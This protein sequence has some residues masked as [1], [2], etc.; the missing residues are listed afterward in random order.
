MSVLKVFDRNGNE[1]DPIASGHDFKNLKIINNLESGIDELSFDCIGQYVPDDLQEEGYVE[2]GNQRF[3][4]KDFKKATVTCR[5][6]PEELEAEPVAD[7]SSE[8]ADL[9]T[10]ISKLLSETGWSAEIAPD[11]LKSKVRN[12]GTINNKTP[13]DIL[14]TVRDVFLCEIRFD[15]KRKVV[16]IADELGEDRGT[17]YIDGLNLRNVSASSDSYDFYTRIKPVGK[18]GLTIAD[19]NGGSEYLEDYTYSKKKKTMIWEATNYDDAQ[20][21]MED[22]KKQLEY[23]SQP[24][25]SFSCSVIDLESTDGRK[26]LHCEIGDTVEVVSKQNNVKT[27]QRV[28]RLTTYPDSPEKNTVELATATLRLEDLAVQQSKTASALSDLSN[29]DG[30]IKGYYVHGVK[31]E[32]VGIEVELNGQVVEGLTN[33]KRIK[34]NGKDSFVALLN[35]TMLTEGKT[36]E[37]ALHIPIYYVDG[38]IDAAKI[39]TG[40]ITALQLEDDLK[41]KINS[42]MKEGDLTQDDIFN[43]LTGDGKNQGMFF[44]GADGRAYINCTY[45]DTENLAVKNGAWI[46]NFHIEGGWLAS[47]DGSIFINEGGF[48]ASMG[49]VGSAYA[50]DGVTAPAGNFSNSLT[51]AGTNVSESLSSAN[52]AA[53]SA[54]EKADAANKTASA[55]REKA[56]VAKE[57]AESAK[58]TADSAWNN[59]RAASD[60]VDG[61]GESFYTKSLSVN[62]HDVVSELSDLRQRVAALEKK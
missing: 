12:I 33:L 31:G 62:G 37:E 39:K 59:A 21:L 50:Y 61:M 15:C 11:G 48:G 22:A 7:F 32:D 42:A 27:K 38:E 20:K 9:S 10:V 57:T 13:K 45:L 19:V 29:S 28:G 54:E 17:Y 56:D 47:K 40:S 2:T 46:G 34:I 23:Y 43:I 52:K 51:V 53:S 58:S 5:A 25:R 18:D 6:E 55:A 30:S 24:K 35:Q 41:N 26:D 1:K 14:D 60:K 16:V 3:V 36:K 49:G 8:N 44:N 4:I